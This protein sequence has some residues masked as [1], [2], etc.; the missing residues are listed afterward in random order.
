MENLCGFSLSF[1]IQLGLEEVGPFEGRRARSWRFGTDAS[2]PSDDLLG[3]SQYTYH[4]RRCCRLRCV[5]DKDLK[6]SRNEDYFLPF[7]S[8]E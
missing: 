2:V 7:R 5:P 6:E 3:I 8:F 1:K 4:A